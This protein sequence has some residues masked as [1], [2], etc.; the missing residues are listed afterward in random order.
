MFRYLLAFMLISFSA[1]AEVPKEWIEKSKREPQLKISAAWS[2]NKVWPNIQKE[3]QKKYP[4]I[5]IKYDRSNSRRIQKN[6]VAI[7]INN[8]YPLHLFSSASGYLDNMLASGHLESL[9]DLPSYKNVMSEAKGVKNSWVGYRINL[10][11]MIYNINKISKSDLPISYLDLPK[12]KKL[13][14]K[15]LA[16]GRQSHFYVPLLDI[17]DK[18]S[19]V[20]YMNSVLS[21]NPQLRKESITLR[22]NLLGLGEYHAAFSFPLYYVKEIKSKGTPIEAHCFDVIPATF[23]PI[24]IIKNNPSLYSSKI[25]VNWLLS[26]EGQ[27]ILW[28]YDNGTPVIKKMFNESHI[29]LGEETRGK[30]IVIRSFETYNED[31]KFIEKTWNRKLFK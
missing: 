16:V 17:M 29:A 1:F 27:E 11:C 25:F 10:H 9:N 7:Q 24:A 2:S 12:T 8:N 21:I 28:K 31:Q 22:A 5:T 3:F 13:H 26:E 4:W 14:N 30:K 6:L 19:V 23:S 15:N 18:K 20:E